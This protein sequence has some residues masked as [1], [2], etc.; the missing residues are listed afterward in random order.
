M[1][2][3]DQFLAELD[4]VEDLPVAY[5][6][7][8]LVL[9]GERLHSTFEVD[10]AEAHETKRQPI[11]QKHRGPIRAPVADCLQHRGQVGSVGFT[12]T[13]RVERSRYSAHRLHVCS[14]S[15]II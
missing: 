1:A 13:D 3:P 7:D 10:D 11:V 14:G 2:T 6:P 12:R 4:V 8:R 9:V 15:A 5:E